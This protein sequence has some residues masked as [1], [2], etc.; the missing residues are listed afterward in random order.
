MAGLNRA[1]S[2]QVVI[3]ALNEALRLPLLL[4]DLAAAPDLL[5]RPLVVD[6][7]SGDGTPAIARLAGAR[8]ISSPPGRGIQ[9]QRGAQLALAELDLEARVHSEREGESGER[10]ARQGGCWLLLLHADGRLGPRW[11]EALQRALAQPPAPWCFQLRIEGS[12]LGLRLVEGAVALRTRLL[13]RPY[14][15]QGLL[16]PS[17]LYRRV[18]GYRPWPLME[19][20]DLVQRLAAQGPVRCLGAELRV[21][22]RRWR[23]QG[24]ARTAWRNWQLRRAWRGGVSLERLA[25]SYYGS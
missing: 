5:R 11:Q 20:L 3:P 2:V 18:G 23:R 7:G 19:D 25:Q 16:I 10:S 12:G 1:A 22:G 4:A 6:G 17:D 14:G 8:V 21:D 24:V 13:H 9:L 15:D